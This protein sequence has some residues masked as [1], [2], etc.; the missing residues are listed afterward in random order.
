MNNAWH[1]EDV[2]QDVY[3]YILLHAREYRGDRGTPWAWLCML[4]RSRA[5]DRFRKLKRERI[6]TE[7]DDG[8][9]FH[10]VSEAT[11]EPAE[12][13]QHSLIRSGVREL[14][15]DQRYLIGLACSDG[16]THSEIA[17]LTGLPLGTVKSRIRSA[18]I[19]LRGW[20]PERKPAAKKVLSKAA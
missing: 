12:V 15:E 4:A 11:R 19:S 1:K 3:T 13:W 18:L 9:R 2:L 17:A 8:V 5:L 7:F 14:P 16:F 6:D 10:V 20:L